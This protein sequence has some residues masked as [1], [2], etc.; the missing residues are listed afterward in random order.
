M[1]PVS[2]QACPGGDKPRRSLFARALAKYS[3]YARALPGAAR[4]FGRNGLFRYNAG[5]ILLFALSDGVGMHPR[6][7]LPEGLLLFALRQPWIGSVAKD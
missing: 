5:D 2:R 7:H 1:N 4:K 6:P 3:D